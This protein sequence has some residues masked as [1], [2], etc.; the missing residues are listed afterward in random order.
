MKYKVDLHVHSAFSGDNDSDPEESIRRAISLGLTGIAFT[1]HYYYGASEVVE[2]LKEKYGNAVAI[3]RGV[4]FSAEEGHCLVFGVDTDRL[5]MKRPTA[6]ELTTVVNAAG[7]VVI[8]SHPYRRGSG[9]GDLIAELE[10]ICAVE[11]Y[12]GCNIHAFNA[13]A[14][15]MAGK[16]K[17]PFTGGSDAH[18]PEE[19]GSCYTEF[20]DRPT[21]HN[22]VTL[23]KAGRY[24]GVDTRKVSR[25][26]N[27]G[28]A[29]NYR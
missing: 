13:L 21:C 20:D 25:I 19:V 17:L 16:I 15:E 26:F 12:N 4:E 23:L 10:G 1:E 29:A 9:V 14:V 2:G 5:L 27:F 8:P 28:P 22:F 18:H 7:G 3:F 11:G 6:R 24:R